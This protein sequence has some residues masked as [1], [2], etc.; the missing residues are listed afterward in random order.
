MHE[1]SIVQALIEQ[2]EEEIQQAGATG[3][4][5]KLD[6]I[7]GRLSGAHADSIRFAFEL[8]TPDTPLAGVSLQIDEQPAVCC[9]A[10]CDA[11]TPIEE[12]ITACPV[13]GSS[14]ITIE[15]GCDLILQSIE[16]EEE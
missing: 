1:V 8:L 15:G 13:C 3:R 11:K 16:L 5:V 12:L 4:V 9:C 14:Q 7:I 6:L 2:V 10:A